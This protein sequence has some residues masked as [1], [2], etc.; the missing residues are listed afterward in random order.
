VDRL[1]AA[2]FIIGSSLLLASSVKICLGMV[3]TPRE[4]EPRDVYKGCKA[5]R[6]VTAADLTAK[7]GK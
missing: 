4:R 1:K 3:S 6:R 7:V 2:V 5:M